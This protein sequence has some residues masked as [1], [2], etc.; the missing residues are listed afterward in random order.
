MLRENAEMAGQFRNHDVFIRGRD[1]SISTFPHHTDV[2]NLIQEFLTWLNQQPDTIEN[3][4]L[5][6]A[7]AKLRYVLIHPHSDGNG[8]TSRA[9]MAGLLCQTRAV[10]Y[11]AIPYTIGQE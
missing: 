3:R 11:V 9:I 2:L 4:F 1:G 6:A 5:V 10:P 7:E 8:R